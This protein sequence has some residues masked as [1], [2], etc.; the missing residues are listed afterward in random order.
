MPSGNLCYIPRHRNPALKHGIAKAASLIEPART[1]SIYCDASLLGQ[2]T[3]GPGAWAFLIPDLHI[4]ESGIE[5]GLASTDLEMLAA[6]RGCERAIAE[7]C[8]R[9]YLNI[10]SDCCYTEAWV[11]E[12]WLRICGASP[13]T[14]LRVSHDGKTAR[15][16]TM[17]ERLNTIMNASRVKFTRVTSEV[18][19]THLRCHQLARSTIRANV[20]QEERRTY[21][22]QS[23]IDS[24][25]KQ[26]EKLLAKVA[27]LDR[28]ITEQE[29]PGGWTSPG[30]K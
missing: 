3:V 5:R 26:R 12:L 29:S 18:N 17:I 15:D 30:F 23:A 2:T 14:G 22:T 9:D 4:E 27:E 28:W 25:R 8:R 7:G 16:A 13:R 11:N 24:A 1:L 20:S 10:C 19:A 6:I 21:I